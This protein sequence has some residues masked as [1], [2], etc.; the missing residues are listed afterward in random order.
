MAQLVRKQV[1][2]LPVAAQPFAA[3]QT[4]TL[5]V[6]AIAISAPLEALG[7]VELVAIC[8]SKGQD[9]RRWRV[10]MERYHYLGDKPLCGAQLRYLIRSEHYGWVGAL[11][12]TSASW[13]LQARD[14]YIG[15][16]EPAR[17]YNLRRVVA[18]ARFRA[19]VPG[20]FQGWACAFLQKSCSV[21]GG[22]PVDFKS[23]FQTIC[24]RQAMTSLQ[25]PCYDENLGQNSRCEWIR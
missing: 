16:D 22:I 23:I 17:R 15:W 21:A 4:P 18:N 3:R 10:L 8:G 24:R 13:A 19:G 9:A 25:V 14:D 6:G 20:C 12:F 2:E 11:A 1:I 7:A 5:E